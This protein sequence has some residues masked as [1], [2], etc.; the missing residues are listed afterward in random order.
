MAK[1]TYTLLVELAD[2]S[3]VEFGAAGERDLSVGWCAYTGSA[4][5]TGGARGRSPAV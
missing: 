4:F 3:T 5:G 2:D 1:R